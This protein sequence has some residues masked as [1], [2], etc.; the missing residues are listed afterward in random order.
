[1]YFL[2]QLKKFSPW[3]EILIQFYRAVIE[4]VLCFSL[5][6]WYGST[7]QDQK[8]CLNRVISSAGRIFG[9]ELPSLE[10]IFTKRFVARSRR[11][12]ADMVPPSA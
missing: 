9:R 2:L 3:S 7:T 10:E 12:I 11:I 8:R 5:R 4:S 1:M 6:I